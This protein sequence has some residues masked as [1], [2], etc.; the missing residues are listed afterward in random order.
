MN[1]EQYIFENIGK[2]IKQKAGLKPFTVP[3]I[4]EMFTDFYYWDTYFTNF[5]LAETGRYAQIAN[6]LDNM[7]YFVEK[8]GY[9]PNSDIA[10][11]RSQPPLFARGVYDYFVSLGRDRE[12]A[13]RYLP[14]LVKEHGFWMNERLLPCG[15]NGYKHNATEEY[16]V[17]F[18]KEIEKRVGCG[19]EVYPD[20]AAQ[21]AHFLAI[22]ESGWDFTPRFQSA[23]NRY[24]GM[25]YAPVDLN[26]ILFNAETVIS[27][28]YEATGNKAE[29]ERFTVFAEERRRKML[30]LMQGENGLLF[31]YNCQE[32]RVSGVYHAAMFAPFAFG[33]LSNS[34]AAERLLSRLEGEHGIY[35]CADRREEKY[36]QWDFP[37][38]WAPFVYFCVEGLRNC[39]SESWKRVA[40]KYVR[41][42]E[43]VFEKTGTL[44][45]KYNAQTG[46]VAQ[47]EEYQTPPML[48]WTAGVY[49]Y[50]KEKLKEEDNL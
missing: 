31:D 50:L 39:N 4:S 14:A 7:K 36:D 48:G 32:E 30:T 41:T 17:P 49:L 35:A 45:E 13:E 29:S 15:L 18:C 21:G 20:K 10:T 28:L 3:C 11:N 43:N 5:A 6:N 40:F 26:A 34:Q 9:V 47:N 42:V 16:L 22:A 23:R 19:E 24:A 12:I 33:V 8:I 1:A 27:A 44:W 37:Y 38:M 46:F 2:T 25:D